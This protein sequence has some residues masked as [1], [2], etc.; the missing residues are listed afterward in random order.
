MLWTPEPDMTRPA[1]I[2]P[3]L[4]GL[5]LG[6]LPY[7]WSRCDAIL[8]AVG[9][10]ARHPHDLDLLYEGTTPA[11]P[12]V[13][14]TFALTAVAR[15]LAPMV[16]ELG[17]DR[18]RLLHAGQS[19]SIHR[20]PPADGR[21]TAT[22]QIIGVR[23]RGRAA[24]VYCRDRVVD[25][26]G[27][28]ATAKSAWWIAGAGGFTGVWGTTPAFGTDEMPEREPDHR[29]VS[30]TSTEQ[31]VIHRLS[32]DLNPIHID[33]AFAR[34][35]GQPRAILHGL[36]TFGWLGRVLDAAAGP[37]R[38]LEHLEGRFT[39]PVFPGDELSVEGWWTGEDAVATVSVRD[40]VVLGRALARFSGAPRA[41][42]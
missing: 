3:G 8:Y 13:A 20:V 40:R 34:A 31:A 21:C 17:I 22:R 6:P 15:L 28:L 18:R 24:L 36:C 12:R 26:S 30:T 38:R 42:W 1:M 10:G 27:I 16:R 41:R 33:P 5:E 14:P 35:A 23:D 39:A 11:G 19:L 9:I 37:A 25:E 32:G 2:G 7:E 4:I 29:H